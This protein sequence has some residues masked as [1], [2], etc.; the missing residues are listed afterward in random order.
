MSVH[1]MIYNMPTAG[2]LADIQHRK[3]PTTAAQHVHQLTT[4]S[5][6]R[7]IAVSLKNGPTRRAPRLRVAAKDASSEGT[8]GRGPLGKKKGA[9]ERYLKYE[10]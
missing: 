6:P 8:S 9:R 5:V 1:K 3:T 2:S 10:F 4:R 7:G